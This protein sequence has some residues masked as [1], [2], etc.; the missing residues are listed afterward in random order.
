MTPQ[1]KDLLEPYARLLGRLDDRVREMPT[2]ELE[3]MQDAC[4]AVSQTNCWCMTYGAA[5]IIGPLIE[6]ELLVR[7]R[8]SDAGDSGHG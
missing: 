6:M 2:A 1:Q 8:L 5:K 3:A 7:S 4:N